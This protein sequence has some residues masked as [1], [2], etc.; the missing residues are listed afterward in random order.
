M[1]LKLQFIQNKLLKRLLEHGTYLTIIFVLVPAFLYFEL[2]VVL[3]ATVEEWS[4]PFLVHLACATFLLM[5]ILGNMIYGMFTDTSIK[6]RVLDSE[7][8]EN[9]TLCAV[10]ECLRPP[11]AWH[12][13]TCDL[14]ILK[15]D[16]HCTFFA[17]CVGYYNHRYFMCFTFYIFVAMVY[18]FYYN[19]KFLAIYLKWNNGLVIGK[20]LFPLAFFVI[21]FGDETFYVFLVE[22][23]FIVAMFTGFLFF[24]HLN[25]LLKGKVTPEI[26]HN[27]KEVT[28]NRGLK[29]N[30]IEVFGSR[31]YL[32]WLSPY[33]KSPLP[34]NGI[35]WNGEDKCK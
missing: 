29:Q 30:V 35:E 26:K 12:C 4:A 7:N 28:Y 9:W 6:G 17:C 27:S 8:K 18:A 24:Y 3:P 16:H 31:W 13:N 25:N 10:C 20:F 34:G 5:N 33:F 19:V 32:V 11:R 23:N 1:L 21:D 14:C 2:V 15:R 22:I